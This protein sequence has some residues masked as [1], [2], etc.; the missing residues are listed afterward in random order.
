MLCGKGCSAGKDAVWE[1]M[2][3]GKGCGVGKDAVWERMPCGKGCSVGKDVV[4]N[5]WD[6]YCSS[7]LV[8][9]I[10]LSSWWGL[11]GRGDEGRE[12]FI[13]S[14]WTNEVTRWSSRIIRT[15][16][17]YPALKGDT[18]S[19][20]TQQLTQPYWTSLSLSS[21]L[22]LYHHYNCCHLPHHTTRLHGLVLSQI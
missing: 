2:L 3:C 7:K 18:R 22:L 16:R 11:V 12:D 4:L 20:I 14:S 5:T 13:N 6:V 15:M 1:R 9:H 8:Y 19:I 17:F 10:P 21:S